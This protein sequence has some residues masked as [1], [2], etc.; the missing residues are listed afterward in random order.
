MGIMGS[1]LI[2]ESHLPW[3][4]GFFHDQ[5]GPI[6]ALLSREEKGWECPRSS[7]LFFH[8]QPSQGLY[9]ENHPPL[10]PVA[11]VGHRRN[12]GELALLL[13]HKSNLGTNGLYASCYY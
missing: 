5:V 3:D 12:K 7:K 10:L 2:S 4:L 9:L 6:L 8:Q 13:G 11:F 1:A